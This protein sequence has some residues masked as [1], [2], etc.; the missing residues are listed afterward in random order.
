MVRY[1]TWVH[2]TPQRGMTAETCASLNGEW[3]PHALSEAECLGG[4]KK[5]CLVERGHGHHRS[6]VAVPQMC[7]RVNA[8]G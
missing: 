6:A 7:R 3:H 8:I 2:R 4:A 1:E 5:C